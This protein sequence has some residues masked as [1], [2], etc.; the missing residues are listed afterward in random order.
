MAN[1]IN[2]PSIKKFYDEEFDSNPH[3]LME[4]AHSDIE[5]W[6]KAFDVDLGKIWNNIKL[7]ERGSEDK[8]TKY[9]NSSVMNKALEPSLKGRAT[10]ISHIRTTAGGSIRYPYLAILIKGSIETV[11]NGYEY[12]H[13][14]FEDHCRCDF[15]KDQKQQHEQRAQARLL[16]LRE[17]E[18]ER[19][20]E[21]IQSEKALQE[22]I[23]Q[24]KE[25]LNTYHKQF[26]EA[27]AELG[28]GPYISRKGIAQIT[29]LS[30]V[31]RMSDD[32][33][34]M[35]T[36]IPLVKFEGKH[37]GK[38]VSYQR[39]LDNPMVNKKGKSI[40]KL[41]TVTTEQN[42]L[43]GAGHQF[44][45]LVNGN[46]ITAGE[47]YAT[48]ASGMLSKNR[49]S[50]VMAYSAS[51]LVTLVDVL[52][53]NYP[54]SPIEVLVDNDH[55][56]CAM[57]KG[58][59]GV[60]SAIKILEKH[61]ASKKV[62][63]YLPDFSQ[64]TPEQKQSS[65]D[66]N[67]IHCH[68]DIDF[69]SRQ[70]GAAKNR[71]NW[72][73]PALDKHIFKLR[74]VSNSHIEAQ[75]KTCVASAMCLVPIKMSTDELF[76][77]MAN[78]LRSMNSVRKDFPLSRFLKKLNQLI[79]RFNTAHTSRAMAF[80]SFSSRI[81]NPSLRP[82][83]INYVR[84][85]KTKIDDEI[86]NY[87]RECNGPVIVRACMGGRKTS[88]LFRPMMRESYR[89]LLLAHRQTLTH[90]L[91]RTM[92][93][94]KKYDDL[95]S[96]NDILHY[97]DQGVSEM[98][99]YANKLVCC[100]NSVIKGIFRPLVTNHDFFGI[101]EATQTLRS[102]LTG[103]AMAY[104]VSV[105]SMLKTALAS[106]TENVVLCDADANDHLIY[107]L[108]RANE[109][110]EELGLEP[111]PQ[112]HV[113]DMPVSVEVEQEGAEPRK[114]RVD[115]SDPNTVF[116]EIKQA[117][118]NG[119]K[120]LLATDSTR[121]AEQVKEF[122]N[123]YNKTLAKKK[124][125]H[126]KVLYVSQDTKPELAV[127]NFQ[128]NPEEQAQM[129]EI[130]LYSPA[131]SSG[132]SIDVHHFTRHFG[133][134]YGEIVP[135]DAIQMLRRDRK[136]T[137]FTL[138]LG[139][140]NNNRETNM[141]NMVR[142]YI[143]VSKDAKC[144]LNMEDGTFS[145]GTHDTEFNRLRMKM[146]VEENRARN[147]FSNQL[148]RIL[149]AD[150]YQVHRMATCEE[151]QKQGQVER[152]AMTEL[153]EER[154]FNLHMDSPTPDD[155]RRE[156]LNNQ[157]CLSEVERAE[158]NRWD[159]E[160]YLQDTVNASTYEFW[161]EGGLKKA[162]LFELLQMTQEEADRIDEMEAKT[163]YTFKVQLPHEQYPHTFI[164][165][166][167]SEEK[168]IHMLHRQFASMRINSIKE[169]NDGSFE[170]VVKHNGR[171]VKH[172][173]VTTNKEA[174]IYSLYEDYFNGKV[175][176]RTESPVVEISKRQH[177]GISR[178]KLVQ[179]LI[180][181]GVNLETGEGEATQDAMKAAMNRLIATEADRDVFNNIC[182]Q[183]GGRLDKHGKKRPTDLYKLVLEQLGLEAD[184]RRESR[185]K[186]RQVV[187]FIDPSSWTNMLAIDDRRKAARVTSY[188]LESLE[189]KD[190]EVIH[191][192]NS[193]S[194]Y[195]EDI[196]DHKKDLKVE[197]RTPYAQL[198]ER[199]VK[200][201]D[202]PLDWASGLL[203]RDEQTA[204]T[205]GK[206]TIKHLCMFLRDQFI[207]QMG[208]DME[209]GEF[210]RLKHWNPAEI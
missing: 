129:Y 115:H 180:D 4:D 32:R 85:N 20:K 208:S 110:R 145:L 116:L 201:L 106:T 50:G 108:E 138:G 52:R 92:S 55:V 34:G 14:K 140:L 45:E 107:L 26:S 66:F 101:D 195:K 172:T 91:Y 173:V 120:V 200:I 103:T 154:N 178:K 15:T 64:M 89:G 71:I 128:D 163:E 202:L 46:V 93:D 74:H 135:S 104:P 84:F 143:E 68:L 56:T 112:I 159:I 8:L 162:K 187:W 94:D 190:L 54:E 175:L 96:D 185:S 18:Q 155:E 87:V 198:L 60:L 25:W 132:V 63:C 23:Q 192:M 210:Y 168:A 5:R 58:N 111:W 28:D 136:A 41:T 61:H 33:V 118:R 57:G 19:E 43:Q 42:I 100:V 36:S 199:A 179:Y 76:D 209:S 184:N 98:A 160:H 67:D 11:W 161:K 78:E 80:R 144:T 123:E 176:A 197:T 146:M 142:G 157:N 207:W 29:L 24:N 113:I 164:Y 122:V 81:T 90:D 7:V 6:A 35:H 182:T 194:I 82:S 170:C 59:P 148:L 97:Q 114:I 37:R 137:Q 150:G 17:K 86:A 189:N 88:A 73:V 51:N 174:A 47:G 70:I 139:T 158:L 181:C 130:L 125:K 204:F 165:K 131:I 151:I 1:Y 30:D 203:N 39:V 72:N 177:A 109:E 48:V 44:G 141:M 206:M 167:A 193:I 134:F 117:I 83:H 53:R 38:T 153:I 77:I 9:C 124:L 171:T 65:S 22:K 21:R 16:K 105:Y 126:K 166:S 188:E 79:Q 196:V 10:L 121:F 75:L 102:V 147:D 133:V 49:Q 127:K 149:E 119:E 156:K 13:E 183:W 95:G 12:L 99:P 40:D 31:R 2:K 152:K 205:S 62:K 69:V 186:G 191:D 3:F 169:C 27:P